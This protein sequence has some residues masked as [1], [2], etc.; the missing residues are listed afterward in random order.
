MHGRRDTL[1]GASK[2]VV[3]L[4]KLAH[5][6]GGYTTATGIQSGPV[7]SC[8]IQSDTK[9]VFCLMHQQLRGLES[10]GQ[11]II[12]HASEI[13]GMHGLDLT[14]SRILHLEPGSFWEEAVDCVRRACGDKGIGARTDTAHDSTMTQ[15]KCPTAM[16]F[17]RAKNGVSHAAHEWTDK[18]D[19]AESA[20]VLGKSVLNF[21]QILEDRHT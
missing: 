13:A 2:L 11:Q 16:V 7:G 9:L 3:E 14:T 5:T 19:C 1:V 20:T 17:A 4:E 6:A 18:V 15:L 10:M 8:N 12:A 21:D